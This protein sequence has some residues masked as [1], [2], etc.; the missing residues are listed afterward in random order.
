M[1]LL[2]EINIERTTGTAV[3]QLLQGD[4]SNIPIEHRTDILVMSA[5]PGDY[6]AL[7]GSLIKALSDKGL[8]V[9]AL[10]MD[11]ETDLRSQLNC[12]LSKP[13][14]L[15]DQQLFNFKKILCFEPGEKIQQPLE[16]VSNIFRCIN[17]FAFEEDNNVLAMPIIATGYQ[18]VPMQ[19]MLPA[20]LQACH[21]WLTNGLPLNCI[22]LV[23]HR[24]EQAPQAT[25]LFEAFKNTL[26]Y[27]LVEQDSFSTD[28]DI[29]LPA[30][31]APT[32]WKKI[33]NRIAKNR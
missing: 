8:S 12:W 16:V 10:A 28:N 2:S 29:Q 15:S 6:I 23:V 24:S 20:L 14:S 3:I 31:A 13:L 32:F 1:Q 9:A 5:F 33:K 30:P 19:K 22:K 21:F 11:K 27:E 25:G 7:E 4:L 18:K 17:T 26:Q